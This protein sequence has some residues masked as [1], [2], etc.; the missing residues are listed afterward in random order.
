LPTLRI[1]GLQAVMLVIVCAGL[2]L[3]NFLLLRKNSLLDTRLHGLTEARPGFKLP[4]LRGTDP[5]GKPAEIDWGV[6]QRR[7]LI[8]V[9]A[10][11]CDA[12]DSTWPVWRTTLSSTHSRRGDLRIYYVDLSKQLDKQYL[13]LH[14]IPFE[15]T[16]R[17]PDRATAYLVYNLR[18][19]PQ[20]ILASPDGRV[21]DVWIGKPNGTR[22]RSFANAFQ[23]Q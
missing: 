23:L 5:D 3:G 13:A 11:G 22:E 17:N 18:T 14:A 15:F 10:K 16:I 7:T 1:H 8:L 21:L 4:T 2:T 6:D 20:A 19:V 12:C 9:F